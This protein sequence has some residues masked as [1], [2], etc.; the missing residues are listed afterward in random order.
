[1]TVFP[2]GT[3]TL[4]PALKEWQ[5]AVT[6]LT[7]GETIV[8]LRKGGIREAKG[9]FTVRHDRALLYPTY[10][11]Q[12]PHLLKPGYASQVEPVA[13]GWHPDTVEIAA[14]ARITDQLEVVDEAR[15]QALLPFH[16]WNQ[17]FVI[18][19]LKW[20]PQQPLTVLLLRVYRL[21]SARLIPFDAAYGGCKSWIE[22]PPIAVDEALPALD[23][24]TYAD[25]VA[26][27]RAILAD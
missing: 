17:E 24:R 23:D 13:S 18:E 27:I 4:T 22:I 10:E 21:S 12:K 26:A 3:Q 11:H 8:V 14:W 19:R 15:L 5:V 25:R 7:A 16:I 1:M 6:A 9:G 2:A 20:Q